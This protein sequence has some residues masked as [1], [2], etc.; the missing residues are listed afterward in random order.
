M[1]SSTSAFPAEER[2]TQKEIEKKNKALGF[3]KTKMKKVIEQHFDD[4][5]EDL[6]GLGE[7]I[8]YMMFTSDEDDD[9][10]GGYDAID[11]PI[12]I[13]T[14][15]VIRGTGATN[16]LGRPS[17]QAFIASDMTELRLLA[18]ADRQLER[19]DDIFEDVEAL[20]G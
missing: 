2:V 12:L 10:S 8:Y 15:Y 16:G 4:A 20:S 14:T 5:G 17:L 6:S 19:H 11:L 13:M 3:E 1:T 7:D 9:T 18:T